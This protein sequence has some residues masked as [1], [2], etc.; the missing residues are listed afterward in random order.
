MGWDEE[1]GTV[2]I[3]E[4]LKTKRSYKEWEKKGGFEREWKGIR[5]I[6]RLCDEWDGIVS[7]CRR[8][9]KEIREVKVL[10]H[11]VIWDK[12]TA[13]QR[14][15]K[16]RKKKVADEMWW[17]ELWW[18]AKS[19]KF[20]GYYLLCNYTYKRPVSL[21]YKTRQWPWRYMDMLDDKWY[22]GV[23]WLWV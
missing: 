4:E 11:E 12:H 23:L 9:V 19:I 22:Y 2:R 5:E 1:G 6:G 17:R 7:T 18:V 8:D 14:I 15:Q 13:K 10:K 20:S 21:M 16:R 3:K